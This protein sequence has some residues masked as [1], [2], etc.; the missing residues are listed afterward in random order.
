MMR[1][2]RG[3]L[4]RWSIAG[5]IALWC[6]PLVYLVYSLLI[7]SFVS[8]HTYE[9]LQE[10]YK[11][12]WPDAFDLETVVRY[13]FTQDWYTTLRGHA[14]SLSA[15]IWLVIGVYVLF[16]G[17]VIR[18]LSGFCREAGR[19][20]GFIVNTIRGL[21]GVEKRWVSGLFGAL[22]LYWGYIFFNSQLWLDE[23]CSYLHFA[24]QGFFF[25]IMSYPVPNNHILFN[26]ICSWL[27][28]IPFL[29]PVWVMRLPSMVAS[30]VN[31]LLIFAVFVRW[32]DFRRAMVVMAGVV[33]VHI[34]SYYSIQGRG[35]QV[36]L[37]FL[38][39]NAI[40]GW[41]YFV[42][43]PGSKGRGRFGYYLFVVTAVLGFYVNPLFVYHFCAV[44]MIL[45]YRIIGERD[46]RMG[47]RLVVAT[48]I[49]GAAVLVLYLP[50]FLGSGMNAV[51]NNKYVSANRPWSDLVTRFGILVYDLRN[52]FYYGYFSIVLLIGAFV[53]FL[54]LYRRG[55]IGGFFYDYAFYYL[56]ASVLA[57]GMV[58]VYKRIYP[59]ERSLCFWVLALNIMFV[60]LCYD[61]SLRFFSRRALLVIVL[62][63]LVKN[64][65]SMR[66]LYIGYYSI[67]NSFDGKAYDEPQ[68][69]YPQL[70]ALHPAS[71]QVT[72][73][74]DS[75][76]V[77]L[78]LYLLGH[79]DA[80]PVLFSRDKALGDIILV[81]D[82]AAYHL[83]LQGYTRWADRNG[84]REF[85][86]DS[87]W[88]IYVS[89][90]L[91]GK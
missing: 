35:Y 79:H 81:P 25:T 39:V 88:G 12:N 40:S 83:P 58:T 46:W 48:A 19:G 29:S 45:G 3:N 63:L 62:F 77:Y 42:S 55:D 60:N 9:Y 50:I 23:A 4:S 2:L 22:L 86:Y 6:V 28:K 14:V 91:V 44:T 43:W 53:V 16:S 52:V 5:G 26:A 85:D 74:E 69:L 30:L 54:W 61:I 41:Y 59:L 27:A 66:S 34:L 70:T 80:T 33:F 68:P 84:R 10:Y 82:S 57:I 72:D 31:Y 38:V 20:F 89:K 65:S 24:R 90:A 76:P 49:V 11:R 51:S 17:S 78:R 37:L 1:G 56:V 21:S 32:A 36:Q 67:R 7:I 64:V 73:S 75:Y 87:S 8:A 47:R 18:F 71:F 13:C 15:G